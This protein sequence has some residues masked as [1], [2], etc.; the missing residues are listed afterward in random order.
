MSRRRRLVP[1][2]QSQA[3][4]AVI[5]RSASADSGSG[6]HLHLSVSAKSHRAGTARE[7]SPPVTHPLTVYPV[8]SRSFDLAAA[9]HG[10]L[11]PGAHSPC[12]TF[13]GD[14]ARG[15]VC[16]HARRVEVQGASDEYANCRR[17]VV[18]LTADPVHF[19]APARRT[20]TQG[21][22]TGRRQ[23]PPCE[24]SRRNVLFPTSP[25]WTHRARSGP[26]ETPRTGV[27]RR[28]AP[29]SGPCQSHTESPLPPAT[30]LPIGR[31]A[32]IA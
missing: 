25:A 7:A 32:P 14:T 21:G 30:H 10:A 9:A 28:D 5:A 4:P 19:A 26:L 13:I 27:C 11:L 2:P 12:P 17:D 3:A 31:T 29:S 20:P 6:T 15:L 18:G 8:L 23:L 24:R 1:P 16:R 22:P